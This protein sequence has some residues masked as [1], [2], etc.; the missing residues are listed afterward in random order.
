M[1]SKTGMG[2]CWRFLV[3]RSGMYKGERCLTQLPEALKDRW[4]LVL[5]QFTVGVCYIR[6]IFL[7]E[8]GYAFLIA[9]LF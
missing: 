6:Y 4:P 5:M 2:S 7:N 1:L 3:Y 9:N 8:A